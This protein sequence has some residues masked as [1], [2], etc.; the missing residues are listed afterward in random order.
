MRGGQDQA[1]RE[2]VEPAPPRA[3][4]PTGAPGRPANARGGARAPGLAESGGA[5]PSRSEPRSPGDSGPPVRTEVPGIQQ[6]ERDAAAPPH[7]WGTPS[8]QQRGCRSPFAAVTPPPHHEAHG[9]KTTCKEPH[10]QSTRVHIYTRKKDSGGA[11]PERRLFPSKQLYFSFST[12]S[13]FNSLMSSLK[14]YALRK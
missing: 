7:P 9:G 6:Q 14:N 4:A 12:E 3:A 10:L 2:G 11:K 8:R 5:R 13:Y 1:L